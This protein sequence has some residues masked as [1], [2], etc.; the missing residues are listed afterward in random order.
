MSDLPDFIPDS[1]VIPSQKNSLPDFI[2]DSAVIPTTQQ[3]P[4][5]SAERGVGLGTKVLDVLTLGLGDE[6]VAGG[7]AAI[8][9][10]RNDTPYGQNYDARLSQV[11]DLE[12]R[13][14]EQGPAQKIASYGTQIATAIKNP[15][16]LTGRGAQATGILGKTL[17]GAKEGAAQGAA[18]GF[19]EGEGG[20][21]NRI[22][23]GAVS[24]GIGGTIGAVFGLGGGLLGKVAKELPEQAERLEEFSIGIRPSDYARSLKNT[25][26]RF[27]DGS[28]DEIEIG[29]KKA[30]RNVINRGTFKASAS[31]KEAATANLKVSTKLS[32][33]VNQLINQADT[34]LNGKSPK[35]SFEKTLNYINRQPADDIARLK[36]DV[37][38][39]IG[40][41]KKE[42]KT[43]IKDLQQQKVS[44]YGKT[45]GLDDKSREVL[46]KYIAADLKDI[47]ENSVPTGMKSKVAELNTKL[48][49]H[50]P[51]QAKIDRL[52]AT[53][54][55]TNLI[56]KGF[57]KART[58]GGVAAPAI[59]GATTGSYLGPVGA[60]AGGLVS[61]AL[62]YGM[63]PKGA[64]Q[65]AGGAR[66]ITPFIENRAAGILGASTSSL[67]GL[68]GAASVAKPSYSTA[69]EG[70]QLQQEQPIVEAPAN[71]QYGISQAP[72]LQDRIDTNTQLTPISYSEPQAFD[73][74]HHGRADSYQVAGAS[75]PQSSFASP[76][77]SAGQQ[78]SY[79][80]NDASRVSYPQ[81]SVSQP[82]PSR[83]HQYLGDIG[84][85]ENHAQYSR[86]PSQRSGQSDEVR[87]LIQQIPDRSFQTS[88]PLDGTGKDSNQLAQ[89]ATDR[90]RNSQPTPI[91]KL[92]KSRNTS[93]S[94]FVAKQPR[95]LQ[96]LIDVESEG[97][98]QATSKAGAQGLAQLM[99]AIQ[100][101]FGVTDP[102]DPE[103]NVEGARK[104]LS[105]E[106]K[107]FNNT[108]MALAAYNAGSPAV[109]KAIK[110]AGTMRWPVV[111]PYLP[112]ETRSY[113]MK[114]LNR[115]NGKN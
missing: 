48:G 74:Q 58:S 93:I 103:Q 97:D 73:S 21:E 61:G 62:A 92:A 28:L 8:D 49:E 38:N 14:N 105:E 56:Q 41:L 26:A 108:H 90:Q 79:M 36:Q 113:V 4:M 33:E 16:Q 31:P 67:P 86:S 76:D 71:Q 112:K 110:K 87:D 29:I 72:K 88:Y 18:Y 84:R 78:P 80:L 22:K 81:S 50:I 3:R 106:L 17:A 44:I 60:A 42:G 89:T 64:G 83:T 77:F 11:R 43:S 45:Y 96:A 114:V 95:I 40:A 47:I 109:R 30:A 107:R 34:A 52:F 13:Y 46:D 75:K 94:Q 19:A 23:E 53:E 59:L 111:A 65:L 100:K 101:H 6:I 63:S 68:L 20:A 15:L 115:L 85:S 57:Q 55:G 35:L 1:A 32:K 5:N 27:K 25:G 99:P 12:S 82:T 51:V 39:Y 104:L 66:S 37:S 69:I 7:S 70:Q 9:T 2:P 54:E 10:L 98:H 24:G 102:F 91:V